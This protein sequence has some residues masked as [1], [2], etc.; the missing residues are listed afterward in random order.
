M[1]SIQK[2]ESPK[3]ASIVINWNLKSETIRCL[4]SLERSE[5]PCRTIVIDNGSSDGSVEEIQETFPDVEIVSLPTN[6]GFARACNIGVQKILA[7]AQDEFIFL[8]NNDATIDPLTLTILIQSALSNPRAAILGP[9]VFYRN[10]PNKIWYAGALRRKGILAALTSG[11]NESDNGQFD[12]V[13]EVDYVFGAA[14]FVRRS[15]FERIGMFDSRFFL[16]LEDLDFCLRA[17]LS[18]WSLQFVPDA[19]VYHI[20]SASTAHNLRLRRYH[21]VNSSILFL[22]KHV[23]KLM[24]VPAFLFWSAVLLRMVG[25][26]FFRGDLDL[27]RSYWPALV[28]GVT[29]ARRLSWREI[30]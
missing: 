12:Q 16:Y 15:I 26:D 5:Y 21:Q 27:V 20:G 7:D 25:T 13:T 9:K 18:G 6:I 29:E 8:L 14:M 22:Q 24:I 17:Q 28:N 3:I 2:M 19:H 30:E 23:T 11:R 10:H 1:Q 4:A